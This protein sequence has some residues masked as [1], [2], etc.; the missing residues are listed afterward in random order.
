[1]KR[2]V[3]GKITLVSVLATALTQ[4]APLI[5]LAEDSSGSSTGGINLLLPN[6]VEFIPMI[7]AFFIMWFVFAKY[8]YPIIMGMIDKRANTIKENLEAAE[9]SKVEAARLL[10]ER[11]AQLDQAKAD[12]AKIIDDAKKAAEATRAQIEAE[13]REE[14]S[15]IIAKANANVEAQK[16]AAVAELQH[17]VADISVSVAGKLIGEDLSDDEHRRIIERYVEEAGSLNAS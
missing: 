13:A 17:S 15:N 6:M 16:K 10:D 5:A 8:V 11:Q 12:A 4:A 9:Q 2:R 3:I 14:A 1:M 7:I